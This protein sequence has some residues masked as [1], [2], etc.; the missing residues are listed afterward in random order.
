MATKY[1]LHAPITRHRETVREWTQDHRADN[2]VVHK[3]GGKIVLKHGLH[4]LCDICVEVNE[5]R[6]AEKHF[7]SIS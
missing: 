6:S 3:R 7:D 5:R 1:I 2:G 4:E